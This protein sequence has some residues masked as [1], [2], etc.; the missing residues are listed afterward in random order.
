MNVLFCTKGRLG[1]ALFRYLACTV[2]SLKYNLP[3]VTQPVT[4][5]NR[6]N[7]SGNISE[8]VY[9]IPW[10]DKLFDQFIE[11]DKKSEY[12]P[13][14]KSIHIKFTGFYQHDAIYK[15]YK[16]EILEYIRKNKKKHYV[17]T[18][19]VSAGDGNREKFYLKDI[20]DTPFDF[21][22]FYDFALHIRLGDM[23]A[24]GTTL[25]IDAL[26]NLIKK[27]EIPS[28]SCIV[29]NRP[30]NKYE[31]TF[32]NEIVEYIHNTKKVKIKIESN[33]IITD[34]HIMKNA[35]TLVCSVST[36]SWCAAYFSKR[37]KRC[38]MPDYP[39]EINP[40]GK[41]KNPIDNTELYNYKPI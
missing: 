40:Y 39:K 14:P 20:I 29:I 27:I 41:C 22:K 2:F 7:I 37:I 35:K 26:K 16:N 28:N 9:R 33:S 5:I 38:Y 6:R 23:V 32:L 4:S 24:I 12:P 19:G 1:N 25:S 30:K 15:K 31:N 11:F 36:I 13:L 17:I 3:Y 10:D 21:D 34:F 8:Y 18:D